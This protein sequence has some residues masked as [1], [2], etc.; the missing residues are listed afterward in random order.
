[1]SVK[2]FKFISPGIFI[3][4]IDNSQL[5][6]LP[7]EVGPVVV[8]RTERGPGMRPV[9]VRSFS[10]FVEIFGNPIA[11]GQGGDVWRNGNYT[12][13]TYAAYA[14]QAYLRNSN[15]LTVVRLLGGQSSQVADGGAGEAGWQVSGSNDLDPAV[16]GGAYG[17]FIFPSASHATPVTGVLAAKWYLDEGSIELSGTVRN[18][19]TIA[20]GS[21]V[22]FKDLNS[23][24]VAGAATVE[25]KVLIKDKDG[26][27]VKE[28][29]F[30]FTRSSSKYLRKVFNTNPTL[31][32]SAITR[33]AQAETYWLGPS[34]ERE[35]ADNISGASFGIIL[36]L[37][38]G[39]NS[40]AN[41]RFGFRAA[42][43][44]WIISQDLQSAF[45]G[46]D[47][48]SMT[49]LI[50]FHTLDSGDDQQ[51]RVKISITDIKASTSE[52][53]P[54]GSFSVEVRDL[55]DNDNSPIVIERFSS[56]NLNPASPNYIGR[57]IGDQ[58]IVWDDTERRYRTY[59]NFQNN[60]AIIR[61][62]V[63]EDVEAAATDARLLPFGSFGPVRFKNWGTVVSGS[64]TPPDTYVTGASGIAHP[65]LHGN[66]NPFWFVQDGTSA[67]GV[68]T[69]TV[70][71]PSIKLRV[72]ASDGDIPDPTDAYF[73][74][75]TTQ[76]GNNRFESS[77]IDIVRALPNS[78]DAFAVGAGT[79]RSYIFSLDDLKSSNSG[80][81]GEVAVYLSGS[82]R[83][84]TSFTAVSGTY[85][86]VLDMGY[87]RFT[88]P[89]VG[90]FDGL[91]IRDKE[92]FNNTDLAGGSDTTNYA[93]YSV[94]RALDTVADPENVEMNLLTV[95][96][97]HNSALTA[98]VLEICE[99]RGDALGLI[100][101]DSGYLP[102]T[103]NTQTQQQNA[104]SVS[105]AITN[106]RARQLNSSYGACYY[107]W[108]QIQDTIS[109]SLVFVPPSVVALGTFSSAQRDSELWFAPAG[110]TRGGLTEGSA[111]IPV[112]QTRTRLSSKE[113]D[114]LY[115]A[116]INPIATFPAEGIVIF[117]QKTLQVT[118]SALDR[119]NVRRLLI[120]LKREI[121][122]ISATILFDQNVP[123][124]W[125]RFLSKVDPFLRSVQS[126][127][128]LTDYRVILDE[129]TTTPELVDRNIMYA[130]IFLK[131]ARAIEFIALDFVITNSGAG[132]ED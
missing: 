58:F 40:A 103:E 35:V 89:L 85:E 110:F 57:V 37:D 119:V 100:D 93:F 39:S 109:D 16:N 20:T 102:Q 9:K 118:P 17:L 108:V 92:A 116:N 122:R 31:I 1:M 98:K 38:S 61:V 3:N 48:N 4:E 2:S 29:A 8:G 79:E 73:G 45:D 80:D 101:I 70:N 26:S 36:G 105:T 78:A 129:S 47:A 30:D 50:K 32:N 15:A 7:D 88:V 90:G 56:V 49:K 23:A 28:T 113:R 54:Y 41:F 33:T 117:G 12:A 55:R 67:D 82:R 63:N 52:L 46:Y 125:N 62:E 68:I 13:P 104:G 14:A 72:S 44:P 115:E 59:G 86:Q 126:R 96:G 99:S 6:A 42:Q 94:R 132:F 74:A 91:D 87:N 127:L 107:P 121:S 71:Y 84:G 114:D 81:T 65:F 11:G 51:K 77:Y 24:G 18:S 83:A 5:P 25:Y 64:D 95:P 27:L 34:Y 124:T 111:G 60:S 112:V 69:A 131:P 10:E 75:D 66:D 21:A 106:L 130:K 123:A 53:D 22:L 120:F 43:T 128:G 76:N 19:T 97:I